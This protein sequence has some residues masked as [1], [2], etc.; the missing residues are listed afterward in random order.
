MIEDP[1]FDY[2]LIDGKSCVCL[3]DDK[4]VAYLDRNAAIELLFGLRWFARVKPMGEE[5]DISS[6]SCE[7]IRCTGKPIGLCE[8][9]LVSAHKHKKRGKTILKAPQDI[10]QTPHGV[11]NPA[12]DRL[13]YFI[14]PEEA[15]AAYI[16]LSRLLSSTGENRH[17]AEVTLFGTLNIKLVN[18]SNR[19]NT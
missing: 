7:E 2:P 10:R 3:K 6:R 17:G 13:D 16:D 1:Q 12:S 8:L 4:Y 19:G 11:Y 9:N 14:S 5:V 15:L 18:L